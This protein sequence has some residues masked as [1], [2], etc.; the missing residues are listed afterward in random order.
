MES[1]VDAQY[2]MKGKKKTEMM[3]CEMLFLISKGHAVKNEVYTELKNEGN[4]WQDFV[5]LN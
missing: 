4:S 3:Q 2:V 5:E 1:S